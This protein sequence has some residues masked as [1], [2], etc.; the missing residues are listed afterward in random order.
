M[1]YSVHKRCI[2]PMLVCLT[3]GE[4]TAEFKISQDFKSSKY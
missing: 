2:I 1:L 4:N 3:D